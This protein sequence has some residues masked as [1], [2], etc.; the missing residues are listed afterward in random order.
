MVAASPGLGAF[1]SSV[2]I[3]PAPLKQSPQSFTQI[4]KFNCWKDILGWQY[5]L[6][7]LSAWYTHRTT[8]DLELPVQPSYFCFQANITLVERENTE[9]YIGIWSRGRNH[10]VKL[11]RNF[12]T[13]REFC[14]CP[15]KRK[16]MVW[17][18]SL[19]TNPLEP[20]P[21]PTMITLHQWVWWCFSI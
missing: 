11:A 16:C 5:V 17:V 20:L 7:T 3:Y 12:P 13:F 6:G 10:L 1:S 19:E 4:W 15:R 2:F 14:I 18:G 21:F 9:E 8:Q